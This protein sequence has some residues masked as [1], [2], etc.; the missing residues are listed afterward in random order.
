M[1][2]SSALFFYR[3]PKSDHFGGVVSITSK[4][5]QAVNGYSLNYWGWGQED[6]DMGH[7]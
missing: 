7:R 5:F 3:E 2:T 6:D 1:F 4:N